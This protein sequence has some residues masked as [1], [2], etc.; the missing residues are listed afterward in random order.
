MN[1]EL[2]SKELMSKESM[3]KES[4]SKESTKIDL[5]KTHLYALPLTYTPYKPKRIMK[6]LRDIKKST[7][8]M[9]AMVSVTS[10]V[11]PEKGDHDIPI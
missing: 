1:K 6:T 9:T 10:I 11:F 7:K 8:I 4:M 3:S 5:E 2:M